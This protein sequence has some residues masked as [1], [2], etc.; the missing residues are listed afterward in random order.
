MDRLRTVGK[1]GRLGAGA[2]LTI[3]IC[4][5][6][7]GLPRAQLRQCHQRSQ[8]LQAEMAQLKEESLQL[9][10]R[11][12][13]LARRALDDARRIRSLEQ[14]QT[15]LGQSLSNYQKERDELAAAFDQLQQQIRA[16]AREETRRAALD[17]VEP[18]R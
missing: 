4:A 12:Q 3:A 8:A 7:E 10:S 16:A 1:R 14:E 5:G 15:Q 13:E 17:T 11:N 6:C 2:I 18:P 9:R